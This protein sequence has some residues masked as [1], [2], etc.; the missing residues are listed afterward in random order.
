MIGDSKKALW[1][2]EE[3]QRLIQLFADGQ[4]CSRD[5]L[6]TEFPDRTLPALKTKVLRLKLSTRGRAWTRD[7]IDRLLALEASGVE[8]IDMV[9]SFEHRTH[10]SILHRLGLLRHRRSVRKL[11]PAILEKKESVNTDG[12]RSKPQYWTAEED[13][14][15]RKLVQRA[16]KADPEHWKVELGRLMS[17]SD[18]RQGLHP[19]RSVKTAIQ[20]LNSLRHR[21]LPACAR[22]TAEE[23]ELLRAAVAAQI[24]PN[25]YPGIDLAADTSSSKDNDEGSQETPGK[26]A[27]RSKKRYLAPHSMELGGIDWSSVS[28]RMGGRDKYNCRRRF[29]NMM[30]NRHVGSWTKEELESMKSLLLKYGDDWDRISQALGTR[31][32][33]QIYM[34]FRNEYLE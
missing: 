21:G 7:E 34:K 31:T 11:T 17:N 1:T 8:P 12:T 16:K 2:N 3:T 26:K 18:N 28:E 19:S 10:L 5:Q 9:K 13:E 25:F 32:P 27:G 33:W 20:R 4:S 6:Q 15:L 24:G 30:T 29:M 23:D 22:W 14:I